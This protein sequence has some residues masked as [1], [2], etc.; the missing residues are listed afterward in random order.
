M[1]Y[2]SLVFFIMSKVFSPFSASKL[3][4]EDAFRDCADNICI[5]GNR[6][7]GK[8]TLVRDLIQRLEH[9]RVLVFSDVY[10]HIEENYG[11]DVKVSPLMKL[12]KVEYECNQR[13]LLVIDNYRKGHRETD[14]LIENYMILKPNVRVILCVQRVMDIPFYCNCHHTKYFYELIGKWMFTRPQLQTF[15]FIS[16]QDR[17]VECMIKLLMMMKEFQELMYAYGV[18]Y[19]DLKASDNKLLWYHI[20]LD[21]LNDTNKN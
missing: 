7:S 13:L 4:V 6:A 8:T 19:V 3:S 21:E 14:M 17:Q 16:H 10:P 15:E 1:L 20:D 18:L 2:I 12:D 5:V 11:K 9:T